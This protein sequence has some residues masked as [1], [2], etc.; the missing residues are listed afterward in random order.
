MDNLSGFGVGAS[1]V[2]AVWELVINT[3]GSLVR[4]LVGDIAVKACGIPWPCIFMVGIEGLHEVEDALVL[5]CVASRG[6]D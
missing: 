1:I 3:L 5:F 4:D 2:D 6:M